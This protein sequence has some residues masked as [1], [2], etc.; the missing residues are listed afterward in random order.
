MYI[1]H[2]SDSTAVLEPV[3]SFVQHSLIKLR[4]TEPCWVVSPAVCF[5]AYT[6]IR[7]S[8]TTHNLTVEG[9]DSTE[10]TLD[11]RDRLVG[12]RP[13]HQAVVQ[14]DRGVSHAAHLQS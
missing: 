7:N 8:I 12:A 5:I 6:F 13:H 2:S 1:V 4:T 10:L 11:A 9:S 14:D 3:K